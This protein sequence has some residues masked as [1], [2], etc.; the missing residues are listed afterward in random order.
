MKTDKEA[1][2]DSRT[3]ASVI[4]KFDAAYEI[5]KVD[6]NY[7]T[8]RAIDAQNEAFEAAKAAGWDYENDQQFCDW[9]LKATDE[10]C[11]AEGKKRFIKATK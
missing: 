3:V 9:A 11:I 2:T 1:V 8:E 6:E 4:A 5:A 10:E 7:G